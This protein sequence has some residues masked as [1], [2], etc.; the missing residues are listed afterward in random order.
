[1]HEAEPVLL[2]KRLQTDMAALKSHH[3]EHGC[4]IETL[5]REAQALHVKV[6]QLGQ[7]L[8]HVEQCV[9]SVENRVQG[10]SFEMSQLRNWLD[11]KFAEIRTSMLAMQVSI[12]KRFDLVDKRFDAVE[13]RLEILEQKTA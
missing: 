8:D 1:M 3:G 10:L 9:G 4:H 5:A 13:K 6:N 11:D 7:Q 2:I 12:D